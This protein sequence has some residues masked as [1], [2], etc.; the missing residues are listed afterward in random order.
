MEHVTANYLRQVWD[1]SK[2]LYECQ[3]G[4]ACQDIAIT[5]KEG[6]RTDAIIIDISQAMDLVPYDHL[7]TKLAS[8]GVDFFF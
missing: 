7:L 4:T 2:W 1:K 8:S 5:L 3:I 6:A